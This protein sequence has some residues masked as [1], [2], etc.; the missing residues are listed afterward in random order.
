MSKIGIIFKKEL[1]DIIR[2]R[3]TIITMI[4]LPLLVFPV[5]ITFMARLTVSH[6]K[7]AQDKMLKVVYISNN[8]ARELS[9][10]LGEDK[11]LI[12]IEEPD[13]KKA[14]EKIK[15]EELDY[16]IQVSLDFDEMIK[17][18]KAGNIKLYYKLSKEV[19]ITKKRIWKTL[20]KVKDIYLDARLEEVNLDKDFFTTVKISEVDI[21]SIQEKIGHYA[22]G[23]L[24]YM[25]ILF[26]FFGA[27]YP[28]IDLG[29]GEKERYTIETLLAS[30]VKRI[31]IVLGKF[32]VV[33][34][35][36]V[37]SAALAIVGLF[38]ALKQIPNIPPRILE[39]IIKIIELK[40]IVLMLSL[41]IPLC[42]LFAAVLLS[43][44][45][46]ANSF[47]EA[48]SLM[49]PMNFVVILPA[50]AGMLPGIKLNIIT[51]LIPILNISLATK[52]IISGSINAGL[53]AV[54]YLVMFSLA[55]ISLVFCSKWFNRE[56]VIFRGI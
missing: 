21:S 33:F 42:A 4:L 41:L 47:K 2:D 36:G 5:I 39:S 20:N 45:I 23:F 34:F 32:L 30:P 29:A 49:T 16:I 14:R 26:C 19:E 13:I 50:V 43:F 55:G 46:F 10:L 44:S 35:A 48:Q 52:D 24:P 51:A 38:I 11:G 22:G 15:R 1:L 27:M 18:K 53:L 12:L 28:A 31:E 17:T 3:R 9:T 7:K 6:A 8:N 56:N 40:S 25:F 54:V 37:I